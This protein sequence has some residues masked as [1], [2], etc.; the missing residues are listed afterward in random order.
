MM[1]QEQSLIRCLDF[2]STPFWLHVCPS[3]T[4]QSCLPLGSRGL[5]ETIILM[6]VC[7][8]ADRSICQVS[9]IFF[10]FGMRCVMFDLFLTIGYYN[11]LQARASAGR[12]PE[13]NV[14]AA[15]LYS[16]LLSRR[17]K[18][19]SSRCDLK[20]LDLTGINYTMR[21]RWKRERSQLAKKIA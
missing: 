7:S 14:P 2:V 12:V 15:A 1:N 19:F 9:V 21:K 16:P 13:V 17:Q 6:R 20:A 11:L 18:T 3:N 4:S 8:M 10:S 5:V